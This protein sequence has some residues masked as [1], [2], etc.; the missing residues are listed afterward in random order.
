MENAIRLTFG[1]PRCSGPASFRL[2][3]LAKRVKERIHARAGVGNACDSMRLIK[4]EMRLPCCFI[5]D[6][7]PAKSRDAYTIGDKDTRTRV[8]QK[9]LTHAHSAGITTVRT[10][11]EYKILISCVQ[12]E[13]VLKMKG[14][15]I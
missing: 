11:Y 10:S 8:R 15:K 6:C 9:T 13:N 3:K 5:R 7:I 2:F 12:I 4:I 14:Y 1:P